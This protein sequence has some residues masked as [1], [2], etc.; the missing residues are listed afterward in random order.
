MSMLPITGRKVTKVT[1]YEYP[2]FPP[3][4]Y[5]PEIGLKYTIHKAQNKESETTPATECQFDLARLL[6]EDMKT[7]RLWAKSY[8][9]AP[10]V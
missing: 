10:V 2:V 3:S 8:A 1:V 7:A 5:N 9:K 6:V 4:C